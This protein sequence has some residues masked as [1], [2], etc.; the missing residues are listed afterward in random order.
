MN[1]E[2]DFIGQ[3]RLVSPLGARQYAVARGW[4]PIQEGLKSRNYLLRHSIDRLRQLVIPMDSDF[5]DYGVAILDLAKRLSEVEERPVTSILADLIMPNADAIR[6]RVRSPR[7]ES[8]SLPLES[9]VI[10]LNG[11][12]AALLSSAHSVEH[13]QSYH[14]RL[15]RTEGKELLEGCR[16][17]QTERG[18]FVFT[19]YC[20]LDAVGVPP[21]LDLFEPDVGPLPFVRRTTNL[22]MASVERLVKAIESNKLDAAIEASANKPVLSANLCESLLTMLSADEE[23]AV[24]L[25]ASWAPVLPHKRESIVPSSV[26]IRHEF[27]PAIE[28]IRQYLRPPGEQ[29]EAFYVGTVEELRGEAGIDGRRAGEVVLSLLYEGEQI[30]ARVSL[31][32]DQYAIADQVHMVPGGFVKLHGVLQ[33]GKRLSRIIDLKDFKRIR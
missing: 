10:L 19:I 29:K 4:E 15:N 13:P 24:T 14:P 20:P 32:A 6:A 28:E 25:S 23:G 22:L 33:R 31:N 16:F 9:A 27:F 1:N 30:P 2:R 12:R 3:A 18:S 17:G 21:T 26:S 7:A 8:G 5:E 11:A